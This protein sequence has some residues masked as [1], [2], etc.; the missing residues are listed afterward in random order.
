MSGSPASI[1]ILRNGLKVPEFVEQEK[2][3]E[4]KDLELYPDDVWIV[5]YPKCGTHWAGQIAKL[6]KNRGVQDQ[7][8]LGA[9]VLWLATNTYQPAMLEE[10]TQPRLFRSHFSYDLLPCGPPHNT[11][12]KY[13]YITRNP[14]DVFVS[15][16]FYMKQGYVRNLE[17]DDFWEMFMKGDVMYGDYYDHL[18]SWLPHRDDNNLLFLKYEDMKKDLPLAVSKIAAFME[19]D[20][21]DET[22]TKIAE[23]TT[24]DAMKKDDTANL[25]QAKRF[26]D[27]NGGNKFMRKGVVGD[28]KNYLSAEQSAEIDKKWR[29]P[30][31]F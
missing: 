23:L 14:K 15:Y 24:F 7:V 17:W 1:K 29:T 21:S 6:I 13:I 2:L 25:S 18:L 10:V 9:S 3:D 19:I 20:L 16:F 30:C 12:C 27:E 31:S 8:E 26:H 5:A 11:P 22:I 4:L 28:W